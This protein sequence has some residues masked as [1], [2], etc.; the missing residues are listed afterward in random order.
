M[1]TILADVPGTTIYL[2]DIIFHDLNAAIQEQHINATFAALSQHNSTLNI[3]KCLFAV[4]EV[5]FVGFHVSAKGLLPLHKI[6]AIFQVPEPS[7]AAEVASFQGMTDY[8]RFLP[9]YS[10]ITYPPCH[11][12]KKD[13]TWTC[14]VA[15]P[16]PVRTLKELLTSP[17]VLAN[18]SLDCPTLVTCVVSGTAA[19]AVL[20]QLQNGI[21]WPVPFASRAFSSTEQKYSTGEREALACVSACER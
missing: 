11:L 1:S 17:P 19:G 13:A 20:S 9:Q 10:L 2:N 7:F 8:M 16:E 15:C 18:F 12:L 6:K 5:D 21:K 3:M 14:S 4:P